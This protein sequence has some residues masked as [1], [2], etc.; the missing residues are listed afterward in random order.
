M[1]LEGEL[2]DQDLVAGQYIVATGLMR[3]NGLVCFGFQ[4]APKEQL[5]SASLSLD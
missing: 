4:F 1:Y 3:H 2:V 5:Y